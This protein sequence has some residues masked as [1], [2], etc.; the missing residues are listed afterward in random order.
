MDHVDNRKSIIISGICISVAIFGSSVV[1]S[2]AALKVAGA[3]KHQIT[4]TGS[5]EKIVQSDFAI[6][7]GECVR[8]G[9]DL[10]ALYKKVGEDLV[11]VKKYLTGHGFS[12]KDI[13]VYRANREPFYK[14]N[15]LGN[16]THE[17]QGY[18]LTQVIEIRSKDIEKLK[19][20][21]R[22]S[23]ELISE[24]IEFE[25]ASPDYF[26]TKLNDLKP[27]M[28]AEATAEAKRRATLMAKAAGQR[29]GPM[30]SATEET[31]Q[32]VPVDS[33]E[34]QDSEIN[35]TDFSEKKITSTVEARFEVE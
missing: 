5:A 30:R 4:V 22:E 12:E 26:Y 27:E 9:N 1:M 34:P 6:W 23:L 7:A 31:F 21:S 29:I 28:Y 25:S 35:D 19:N 20:L 17:I 16:D 2:R 13:I 8:R 11:K 18:E 3:D 10:P 15:D 33:E 24:G 32:V 14:Q